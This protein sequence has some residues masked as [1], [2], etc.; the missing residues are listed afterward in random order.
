MGL[1]ASCLLLLLAPQAPQS[2]PIP[3]TLPAAVAV[4]P[5]DPEG[6]GALRSAEADDT[7]TDAA[8]MVRLANGADAII[9]ARAAW[10]LARGTQPTRLASLQQV[11]TDSPHAEARLQA[12]QAL[13]RLREMGSTGTAVRALDDRD[14]RVRTL[15][16]Q[17]L[18]ALQRP[19][20]REPL[21]ALLQAQKVS[22]PGP[23][24]DVQAALLAL[25][26]LDAHDLLLRA[27]TAVHDGNAENVGQ[28]LVFCLQQMAPKLDRDAQLLLALGMLDHREALVRRFAITTLSQLG[29]PSHAKALQDRLQNET[30]ELR[31]LLEVALAHLRQDNA[32]AQHVSALATLRGL[33]Q[34]VKAWWQDSSTIEKSAVAA[35]P[36]VLFVLLLLA[37]RR[38]GQFAEQT[39]HQTAAAD[40]EAAAALVQ[41]S[42][43]FETAEQ[44]A[45]DLA[46]D[47]ETAWGEQAEA[48][49]ETAFATA[50]GPEQ[51][52]AADPLAAE[53]REEPS[54]AS[55]PTGTA[56]DD[57]AATELELVS[58]GEGPESQ[59][60]AG[61]QR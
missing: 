19:T 61:A 32:P 26:D 57:A 31:P 1:L 18:G 28:A 54:H 60:D 12:L 40:A 29:D 33:D 59:D 21:L 25:H 49:Q 20:A 43:G 9:A 44:L 27:A 11:V 5:Q 10:L 38:R 7:K 41:P 16:A 37:M 39:A 47:P 52:D 2:P 53:T 15:A 46:T 13:L 55:L 48:P 3:V 6:L 50:A 58:D 22:E 24:T 45:A 30:A 4:A 17:L 51:V 8:A 34:R 14:R 35:V 36:G 42:A 56:E 23:A